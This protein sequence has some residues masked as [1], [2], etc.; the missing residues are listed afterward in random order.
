MIDKQIFVE[1]LSKLV[2]FKTLPGDQKTNG[3][4][5]DYVQSLIHP[6]AHLQRIHNGK[7]EIF[8]AS[9]IETNQPDIGYLVHGDVVAAS[10]ALFT[11]QRKKEKV[12][13]RGVSDM[14]FSLPIGISL[15]N[16]LIEEKSPLSFCLAITTDE[17]VGGFEGAAF[18]ADEYHWQPKLLI[19]PDGGDNLKF[20]RASKGVAQFALTTFGVSAHASRT[21]QGDNAITKMSR[22]IGEIDKV[23]GKNNQKENWNT[24]VNFGIIQGGIS[25][26]QVCNRVRL[27]IDF[28]YPETETFENILKTLRDIV[29]SVD[30]QS[31]IETLSCGLPTKVDTTIPIVQKFLEALEITCGQTIQIEQN[32]GSSDARHFA[33]LGIP[34]LMMKPIGGDI[35]METEWLDVD[36]TLQFYQGL[37]L[38]LQNMQKGKHA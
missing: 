15:L 31:G 11:L 9:N 24:T 3:E 23:F 27:T 5:L 19:V 12:F 32:Y 29:D 17:E 30:P 22:I 37:R 8:L 4:A 26:N 33:S 14:K 16:E 6:K 2:A 20:V 10:D 36:S 35:H 28:R 7:A 1:Q 21:W 34:I 38:F 18:L 25:T 13:G